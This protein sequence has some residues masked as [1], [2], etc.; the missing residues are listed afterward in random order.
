MR[1]TRPNGGFREDRALLG[2]FLA[3]VQGQTIRVLV[4]NDDGIGAPGIA[5]MID[6]LAM[7]PNLQIDVFAPATNQ[8]GTTVHSPPARSA[9]PQAPRR[10]A[11]RE[12]P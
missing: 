7:N 9:S 10:P 12:R 8:S 3:T 1:T 6:Q 11:I 5:A 4:T 2:L